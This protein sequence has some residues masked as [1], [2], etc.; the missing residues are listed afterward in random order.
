M[1]RFFKVIAATL[2]LGLFLVNCSNDSDLYLGYSS[3]SRSSS[4]SIS[5]PNVSSGSQ[6]QDTYLG[7]GYDVINSSYINRGDVKILHPVLD[8]ERIIKDGLVAS[9][10]MGMQEFETFYG[11]SLTKFYEERNKKIGL[12]LS[13]DVPFK[14]VLFSGGFETEFGVKLSESRIDKNSYLRG[15]S[16]HYNHH[17]YISKGRATAE[18]LV[19]YLSEGFAADLHS[20][21]AAKILDLYGSHVFIQYYKGGVMEYNYAYYG[22]ELT[23]STELLTALKTSLSAKS[24]L[25]GASIGTST[26]SNNQYLGSISELE[27]N[28]TFHSYTYGGTLVNISNPEQIGKN[29]GT[30]INSIET[31]SDICG[32]GKFDESFIPVWELVAA[33][34]KEGLAEELESEFLD[35][36][37]R[38]GKNM[39]TKKSVVIR[40]EFTSVGDTTY[41]FDKSFPATVEVY[42]LGAGGGGQGGHRYERFMSSHGSGVGGSGGGG[43]A[44]YVK[45]SAEKLD[46]FKI[47]VG[48]G[49]SGG[50][51]YKDAIINF[52]QSGDPG[53]NG[54][55]TSVNFGST[56][57]TA[58]GGSG[59]G[60][61]GKALNY[62]S[63]G[64]ASSKPKGDLLEWESNNGGDGTDGTENSSGTGT[65]GAA[66]K[67]TKGSETLGGLGAINSGRMAQKGG[68]GYGGYDYTQSGSNGGNGQVI[69]VVTYFEKEGGI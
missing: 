49:G 45:F 61:P 60:G 6:Q 33:S 34:G 11:N 32:I 14:G 43:A 29:Y 66:A 56:V 50:A 68:G 46:T 21:T 31:K 58:E 55:N 25:L 4:S 28:S 8:Q 63:G 40:K 59:G 47:T 20:K 67:I 39:E 48:K 36:V 62:G 18:K 7:Y 16:Y 10:P 3:D 57:I 53:T 23:N 37:I 5:Q 41:T 22:T 69:I 51:G 24:T 44:T 2:F 13:A 15:R 9:G 12:G 26:S 38:Q 64:R 27:N 54:G 42:V 65:G 35:R 52:S 19:K 30:W 1:N 17:E